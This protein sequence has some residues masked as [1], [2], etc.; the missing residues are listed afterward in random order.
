MRREMFPSWSWIAWEGTGQGYEGI[1]FDEALWYC[2][3]V[4][5]NRPKLAVHDLVLTR[6][7][8]PIFMD[9]ENRIFRRPLNTWRKRN[10]VTGQL[11]VINNTYHVWLNTGEGRAGSLPC[12]KSSLQPQNVTLQQLGF[13]EGRVSHPFPIANSLSFQPLA[14]STWEPFLYAWV[15]TATLRFAGHPDPSRGTD[16][17][18]GWY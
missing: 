7:K 1:N 10:V 2:W 8:G 6:R 3:Y 5:L 15:Q 9:D 11:E 4:F 17:S 18:Y 12:W 16:W 13:S 14:P